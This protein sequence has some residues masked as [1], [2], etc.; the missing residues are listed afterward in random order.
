MNLIKDNIIKLSD[1]DILK[2]EERKLFTEI[3]SLY[4]EYSKGNF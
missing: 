3:S 1:Y 4:T 2:I